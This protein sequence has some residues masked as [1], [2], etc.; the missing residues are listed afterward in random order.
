M[1]EFKFPNKVP[2][3]VELTMKQ[4]TQRIAALEAQQKAMQKLLDQV[5]QIMTEPELTQVGP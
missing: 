2:P 3:A 5:M 1:N 4:M